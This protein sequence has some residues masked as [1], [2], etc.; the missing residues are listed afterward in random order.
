LSAVPSRRHLLRGLAGTGLGW[1]AAW[2]AA[3]G[4]AKSRGKNK[5]KQPLCKRN[6]ARCRKEGSG[7][8]AK[9][10]L[11]AP[12]TIEANWS[13]EAD[14]D[15]YLFVPH[16]NGSTGPA[17]YILQ[18]C[19][20]SESACE[21]PALYPHACVSEDERSAGREITTIYKLLNGSYEYWID[22]DSA[23]AAGEQEI[24]LRDMGGRLV[25]RWTNPFNSSSTSE[26]W[27]VFDFDGKRGSVTSIDELI[28]GFLPGAA[29]DPN[30]YVCPYH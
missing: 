26:S 27:H 2:L 18:A 25:R 15:T 29:H 30:T 28:D 7:C 3:G 22:L 11:T 5:T 24:V 8:K 23:T 6:G 1:G 14:H 9:F 19:N 21:D 16:K 10:C 4:E 13:E 12:F 20:P 17:P